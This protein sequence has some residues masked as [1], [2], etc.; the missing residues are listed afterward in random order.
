MNIGIGQYPKIRGGGGAG[1]ATIEQ[2]MSAAP[3][4]S[5]SYWQYTGS[6][7]NGD[8]LIKNVPVLSFNG[9]D[10]YIQR[11]GGIQ[12]LL[13]YLNSWKVTIRFKMNSLVSNTPIIANHVSTSDRWAL[14]YRTGTGGSA[15][16]LHF[17]YYDGAAKVVTNGNIAFSDT[18]GFHEVVLNWN[19]ATLTLTATLDGAPFNL[20]SSVVSTPTAAGFFVANAG[21]VFT[22]MSLSY[23]K[24]EQGASNL[25]EYHAQEASGTTIYDTSGNAR[26]GTFN[27]TTGSQ[28]VLTDSG[29]YVRPHNLL[30]GFKLASGVY[31]PILNSGASAADGNPITNPALAGYNFAPCTLEIDGEIAEIR[32]VDDLFTTPFLYNSATP[33]DI[34]QFDPAS[35][36][37]A[38]YESAGKLTAEITGSTSI[39]NFRLKA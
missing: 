17:V 39:K 18:T 26:H 5:G 31:I 12:T 21:S 22:A 1:A 25:L 34:R 20:T 33:G 23:L 36:I 4:L 16:G 38:D 13:S 32:A 2:W 10:N 6:R 30:D 8:L 7:G 9:T 35:D 15:T 24:I 29:A 19:G 14:S 11:A 27:G 28:W 3:V 37:V